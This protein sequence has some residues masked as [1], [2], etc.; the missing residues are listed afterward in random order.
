MTYRTKY[1]SRSFR[2]PI[3]LIRSA[4]FGSRM[5]GGGKEKKPL[6]EIAYYKKIARTKL[7]LSNVGSLCHLL[8]NAIN[9]MEYVNENID[10]HSINIIEGKDK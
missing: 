8:P 4:R 1:T 10:E 6:Q 2:A 7:S 5:N 3:I 9:K